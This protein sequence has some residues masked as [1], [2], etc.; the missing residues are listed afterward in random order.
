MLSFGCSINSHK[1]DI[2]QNFTH[3]LKDRLWHEQQDVSKTATLISKNL[4]S[5]AKLSLPQLG[6]LN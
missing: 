5:S 4:P 3:N 1:V 2:Y 6:N